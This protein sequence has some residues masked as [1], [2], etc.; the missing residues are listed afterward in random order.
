[1]SFADFF[2]A[3]TGN[4]SYDYQ[5]RL[6]GRDSGTDCRSQLINIPTGLGKTAAVVLA[7]LWNRVHQQNPKWPRRLVYCLPMRTLVEQTEREVRKWGEAHDLLWNGMDNRRGKVG[8]HV[9][10]G[11]EDAGEWDIFPEENA[12]LIGTQDMLL[13]RV[14]NRG[15]G[16]SRYR[17]PMHFGLLNNDCLWVMDETQ[18]MGP[19]IGTAC[20]L[21]AFRNSSPQG[22]N[23]FGAAAS[24]T[25]YMSATN[26]PE[27]LKTREWRGVARLPE[28]EF[29]LSPEERAAT[30]GPIHQRRHAV[31]RLELKSERSFVDTTA[32]Q[33]VVAEIVRCHRDMV[34]V[35]AN[36][37]KLPARTL[38]ICNTVDRAVA[39]HAQLKS[40]KNDG[41]DLLLLHSRFRPPERREQ[42][43]RLE[44]VDRAAFPNGQIVVATQVIEAG[45][46]ISSGL[47]WSEV[48]PLASLVQRLGR[49]NRAGEF[50][51]SAWKPLAFVVGVGVKAESEGKNDKAREEIRKANDG[52]CL[53]Y[54]FSSCD[55][56]TVWE[57]LAKLKGDASPASLEQIQSEV[58]DSIPPCP[59]SLQ[60]HELLDFFDTDANLSLGF[61]DVSPFVRGLDEDTDLQVCWREQWADDDEPPDF[62][63]DYQ[64]D[65]LCFVPISQAKDAKAREVLNHGWIW[66]GKGDGRKNIWVSVR[67]AGLTPGMTILLP[68]SAGGYDNNAGWT[69]NK[70]DAKHASHYQQRET[71]SDE[72]QLSSLANGW[73]S[74]AV[75]TGAVAQELLELLP[76]L[77]LGEVTER[78]ALT[79]AVPWHDIGK[80]HPG[81]QE[82][83]VAA[84]KAAGITG[85]EPHQPFAKFSLS[86]SPSLAGLQGD[87]R[88]KRVRELKNSFRP[89]LAHEVAS[90][91]AFRKAE[92][93]RLDSARDTD[94]A[95]LL[96]EYVIMSHH[97]R[98]RK[99]LRDEIPKFPKDEKDTNTVRGISDGDKLPTVVID[100]HSL[101]C[102]EISTDCRRMGRGGN[103]HE[104]YT[105]GVLRLLEHHGPFRL[106]FFEAIFRAADIR[107]SK[108]AAA[109]PRHETTSTDE[110]RETPAAYRAEPTSAEH[111]EPWSHPWLDELGLRYHEAIARKLRADPS[112]RQV[113]VDNIDR[114]MARNDYPLSTQKSLLWWR[115]MLTRAPLDDLIAVM[116]DPSETGNQRRQNT[117]FPGILTQEER[118]AIRHAHEKASTP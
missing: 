118:R 87:A 39:V 26:N 16:M 100:G 25:W 34:T 77:L 84:L 7:W 85:M 6:A 104:S 49:L 19:G 44:S 24:V 41:C 21:E 59:Y 61:T 45:V 113:A 80:N 20:Q 66:R 71:P 3:A 52:R 51:Q 93:A 13:S 75:H 94:L 74:I 47:L 88:R 91:L 17:W 27:H 55:E 111:P 18:L 42:M 67:D 63:P 116:L 37:P 43:K 8:V 31:K 78:A 30:T 1:M 23:S 79:L 33:T 90:A 11:G 22:F 57:P 103:G 107:A 46:D 117:P 40:E 64:R 83:V 62:A 36:E 9:L 92:Q 35:I 56:K 2:K 14:L 96:S 29:A 86:D 101:G 38:I 108:L 48:A 114:W 110:L 68:L 89:G 102:S 72:E 106:A 69:G 4:S 50:N 97:G 54:K 109:P 28:F 5:S 115:D 70:A 32:I 105:R 82:A 99:V 76:D 15:Y 81:W 65:E 95:S 58:A 10:M 112:L 73:Q 60:R 12:I 53:P 98:V